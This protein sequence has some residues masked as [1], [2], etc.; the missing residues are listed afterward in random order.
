MQLY[1]VL[2]EH[3][4]KNRSSFHTPGHKSMEGVFP[5]DL[6]ALDYTELPDTDSLYEADG[7]ILRAEQAAAECF[8]VKRTVF[9]AGGCTLC[10]QAMLRLAAPD[11]GKIVMGRVIHRSAVNALA[12]LGLTPV[13]VAP[14]PDAGEGLPGRVYAQDVERALRR[15]TGVKAVYLTSPDYYGVMAD[16]GAVSAVCRRYGVPLLVD[17]AHGSHLWYAGEGMHPIQLGASMTADSPHKTL[18]ALTGG[19]WLQIAEEAYTAGAKE[20]MALFGS[21]SPSYPIMA[22]LDLCVDWLRESGKEAYSRLEERAARIKA[23]ASARGIGQPLGLC[24][25]TRISLDVA[26]VG[27]TGAQGADYLRECGIE[28]EMADGG[29]VVLIAT[30]FNSE[31]DFA[32]LEQAIRR[33]PLARPLPPMKETS[34][35]PAEQLLSPREAIL[36]A[37]ETR[38]VFFSVGEIAAEAAC[39]CPPGVPVV[40]PG[41]RITEKAAEFLSSYGISYIKVLK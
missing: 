21:T 24:D 26:S 40:M 16:V 34:A 5:S 29:Y 8:H 6:L 20:A 35:P 2:R 41:E 9:S 37:C 10:I 11:G 38:P 30:P 28:P 36:G 15:E 19:A 14:R 7:A 31:E 1:Q 17:N 13:W 22:S 23:V 39:P 27:M 3:Q 32:R 12:L 18:P 4:E 25:P 33:M